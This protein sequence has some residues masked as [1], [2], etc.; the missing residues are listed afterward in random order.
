M[1]FAHPASRRRGSIARQSALSARHQ[2]SPPTTCP[3]PT[4]NGFARLFT[5]TLRGARIRAALAKVTQRYAD[6]VIHPG[7]PR[8][9]AVHAYTAVIERCPDTQ[10]P[11]RLRARVP[12]R[13]QPGAQRSKK[14]FAG[15]RC[16]KANRCAS[17]CVQISIGRNHGRRSCARVLPFLWNSR[18]GCSLKS[19]GRLGRLQWIVSLA[20]TSTSVSS[21][22]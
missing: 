17:R 4:R 10:A 12:R 3:R 14:A 5:D 22:R 1:R 19:R 15:E 20:G 9:V 16:A 8:I 6:I 7:S 2:R 21:K 11:G 18:N 13:A